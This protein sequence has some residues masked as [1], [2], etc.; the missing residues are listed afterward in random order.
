MR[1]NHEVPDCKKCKTTKPMVGW[2]RLDTV[3]MAY[4][5]EATKTLLV[6]AY[7][8]PLAQSHA[9][10]KSISAYLKEQNGQFFFN[11]DQTEQADAMFRLAHLLLMHAFQLQVKHFGEPQIEAAVDKAMRDYFEIW[12]K[13]DSSEAAGA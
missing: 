11:R 6:P 4:Q 7:Y 10:L 2:N 1:T 5:Y 8:V 9:T 12:P 13:E 3:A